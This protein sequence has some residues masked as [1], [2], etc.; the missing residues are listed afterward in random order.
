M[1]KYR[2][3]KV[4]ETPESAAPTASGRQSFWGRFWFS[5]AD[6]IGLHALRILTG[7]LML[8][9]L[10]TL[11]G[12]QNSLFGLSGWFDLQAFQETGKLADHPGGMPVTF[13][14]SLLYPLGENAALLNVAYGVSIFVLVL[15]TLGVA[16]RITSVLTWVI[17]VSFLAN[18]LI[19]FGA[20]YLLVFMSFYLMI[21]YVFYGQWSRKLSPLARILGPWDAFIGSWFRA[22]PA[23]TAAERESFAANLAVRLVQVHFAIAILFSALHKLQMG[24]WWSGVALWYPMHPPFRTT[25]DS[26]RSNWP[27]AE[28]YLF[29]MSIVQYAVLGWQ[30]GFPLFAW[31]RSWWRVLLFGGAVLGW[32]GSVFVFGLPM[33][34]PIFFVACL[35]YLTP[36]EWRTVVGWFGKIASSSERSQQAAAMPAGKRV[37][38][39]A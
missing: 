17:A 4:A 29:F 19:R 8:L 22:A 16:P 32:F 25:F 20:D 27:V 21:G 35:S 10:V 3:S 11:F 5:P 13:H 18:P 39:E 9:W 26:V 15:F 23:A 28:S 33:F 36:A 37:K 12:H 7:L 24:D 31:R 2:S 34:G 1:K 30:F 14:W 6:P 38:V